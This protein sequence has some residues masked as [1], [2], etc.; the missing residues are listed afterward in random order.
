MTTHDA[1]RKMAPAAPLV[2]SHG[3][4]HSSSLL[5][6]TFVFALALLPIRLRFRAYAIRPYGHPL[7]WFPPREISSTDLPSLTGFGR[8]VVACRFLPI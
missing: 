1:T 6:Q 5:G 3:S 8:Y 4:T 7:I 2:I